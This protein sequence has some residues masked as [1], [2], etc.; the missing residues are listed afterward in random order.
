M[1]VFATPHLTGDRLAFAAISTSYLV[2]AVPFEER[3][4]RRSFG[5]AYTRYARAV[6]WRI[7]PFIY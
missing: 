3:S 1:A 4:L 2:A 7:V 6:R 5:E